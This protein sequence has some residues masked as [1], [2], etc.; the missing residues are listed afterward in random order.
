MLNRSIHRIALVAALLFTTVVLAGGRSARAA[1]PQQIGTIRGSTTGVYGPVAL[2]AGL[3]VVRARSNGAANFA[4]DLINQDP[5]NPTPVTRDP[6]ASKDF[7][8]LFDDIGRFD[9]AATAN[10]KQDDAYYMHV[11]LASGPFEFT[12]EQPTPESVTSV[13]QSSFTGGK[14]EHVTPYFTLFAGTFTVSAQPADA[15]TALRVKLYYVDDLGGGAIVSDQTGYYGDELIDTT[16]PPSYTS[17]SV[18][19]P[20]DGVYLIYVSSGGSG[21]GN[22]TVSVQ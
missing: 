17:V 13:T 14:G 2:S 4:A 16:I 11:S 15:N 9:G 21:S 22:W 1:E 12:F 20:A 18:T 7:Y 8:A 10:L 19:I 6:T 5:N 3:V